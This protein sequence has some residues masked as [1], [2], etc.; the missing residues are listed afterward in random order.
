LNPDYDRKQKPKKDATLLLVPVNKVSTVKSKF[1]DS[2]KTPE[3]L[4]FSKKL[5]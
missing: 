4:F 3:Y 5:A 2:L 1:S